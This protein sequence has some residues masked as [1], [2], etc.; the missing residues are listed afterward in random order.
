MAGRE[1]V[2]GGTEY[3][4]FIPPAVIKRMLGFPEADEDL[5]GVVVT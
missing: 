1:V 2:N 4:Q 5:S 3:A